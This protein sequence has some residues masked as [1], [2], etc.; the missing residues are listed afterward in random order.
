MPSNKVMDADIFRLIGI[1][2]KTKDG[3]G[4]AFVRPPTPFSRFMIFA[5]NKKG[6]SVDTP[7][8]ILKNDICRACKIC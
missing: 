3:M 8:Y 6:A 2:G 7:S 1:V 4:Q 5:K